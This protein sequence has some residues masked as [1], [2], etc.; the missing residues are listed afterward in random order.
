M[1]VG[2]RPYG[3]GMN[4]PG[5]FAGLPDHI[6]PVIVIIVH[7]EQKFTSHRALSVVESL[8]RT[9]RLQRDSRQRAPHNLA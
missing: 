5:L 2:I 9:E 4:A 6:G 3:F 8:H 1:I 7:T